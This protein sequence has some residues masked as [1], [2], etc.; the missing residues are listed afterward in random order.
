MG[1]HAG[2][3]PA[4]SNREMKITTRLLATAA[5]TAIALF[6]SVAAASACGRGGYSYA[7]IGAP[8][9]GSGISAIITPLGPFDI[10]NGHVAGW[11]GVGGPGQ[12]PHGTDEWLQI[13][14]SGFPGLYSDVY[15]EVARPNRDPV[16]HEVVANPPAGH[17]YRVAVLEDPPNWWRVWLNGRPVSPSIYLPQSHNEFMP[18]ATAEAWDGGTGGAC[19]NFLYSFQRV[20]I[21]HRPNGMFKRFTG[22]YRIE[23]AKTTLE[24][25]GTAFIAAEGTP[26]VRT[27][28][29]RSLLLLRP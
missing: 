22:G 1:E 7:G 24:R 25:A 10:A 9:V 5:V 8:M 12:G 2:R 18:I 23:S 20:K 6:G 27:L 28:L 17:P 19:N 3:H 13:G 4:D 14:L 26:S 15:Y 29:I 16:Y 11:V 21:A